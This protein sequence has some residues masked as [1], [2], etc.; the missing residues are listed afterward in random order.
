MWKVHSNIFTFIKHKIRLECARSD[1]C[2]FSMPQVPL[3]LLVWPVLALD[4][5]DVVPLEHD[6]TQGLAGVPLRVLL[7]GLVQDEVHVLI[8]TD[9]LSLDPCIDVLVEPDH[10]PCSVLQISTTNQSGLFVLSQ[11]R[12]FT[13]PKNQVDWL[14]HHLLHFLASSVGHDVNLWTISEMKSSTIS[15]LLQF[16]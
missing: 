14:Y 6:P 15:L 16:C 1:E 13:L 8:K 12:E 5:G 9:N 2:S 7:C 10:H 11:M 3:P 4:E